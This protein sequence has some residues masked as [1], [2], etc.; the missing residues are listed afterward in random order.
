[1]TL[2][3]FLSDNWFYLLGVIWFIAGIKEFI[4]IEEHNPVVVVLCLGF[5]TIFTGINALLREIRKEKE[6][7]VIIKVVEVPKPVFYDN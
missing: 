1:M 5:S 7:P 4:L 6:R 2:R 3:K